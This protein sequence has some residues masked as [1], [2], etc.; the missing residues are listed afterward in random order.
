MFQN[1]YVLTIFLLES[2]FT[3]KP[4]EQ[5]NKIESDSKETTKTWSTCFCDVLWMHTFKVAWE[6][7]IYISRSHDFYKQF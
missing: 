3:K 1:F 5:Q 4:D 2:S 6:C 7:L